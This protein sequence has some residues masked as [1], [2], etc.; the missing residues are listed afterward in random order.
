MNI[1]LEQPLLIPLLQSEV[2]GISFLV[3]GFWAPDSFQVTVADEAL[4]GA[5][6]LGTLWAVKQ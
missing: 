6:E 3:S 1:T 4:F 2:P 5:R